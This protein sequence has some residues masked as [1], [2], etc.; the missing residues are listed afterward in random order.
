MSNRVRGVAVVAVVVALLAGAVPALSQATPGVGSS[1]PAA[2]G[3]AAWGRC[4]GPAGENRAVLESGLDCATVK[5]PLSYDDPAGELIDL[6]LT[7]LPARD[8]AKRVGALL[9]NPGGP[10]GSGNEIIAAEALIGGIFPAALR[11][12]FDLIGFDPRGV[13][14]STPVRCDPAVYNQDVP[15]FPENEAEFAARVAYNRALGASCRELTG[16]L[17]AN[18]DTVS[19][20]R[21]IEAI[22]LALGGE[23][24]NYLGMSYGTEL[25]AQYAALYPDQIRT[26]ALDGALDHNQ[27]ELGMLIAEA[28]SY[29]NVFDR[30]VAWCAADTS[31][32]LHGEDAGAAFDALIAAAEREPLPAPRCAE[33]KASQPCRG[34]VSAED[35]RLNAQ[36]MLLIKP[37]TP[38]VG[39]PGWNTLAEAIARARAGD[40]SDFAD[41]LATSETDRAFVEGPAIACLDFPTSITTFADL[42]ARATLGEVIAPRMQGASQTW[43]IQVGCIGWP[44]PLTNPPHRADVTG[45]PPMLIINATNDPSTAYPWAVALADEIEGSVLLTRAGDGHT[46]TFLPAPSATVDAIVR[47]LITGELPAPNTVLDS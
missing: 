15:F 10:G 9:Y 31:C 20:A 24:L 35:L 7:R 36:S 43:T 46:S 28:A 14:A 13:G 33:Q 8:R 47:Y 45:T 32:A 21:D 37:P 1:T 22:R 3:E 39:D 38:A 30:F 16:P 26:M 12:R 34:T 41:V 5:V 23:P 27:P 42:E 19:A 29:E 2:T 44:E 18:I 25:G 11:D 6:V 4:P 17:L 40:A